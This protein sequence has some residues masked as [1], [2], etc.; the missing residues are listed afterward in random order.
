MIYVIL[1]N[2]GNNEKMKNLQKICKYARKLNHR[3]GEAILCLRKY[4]KKRVL[5]FFN[6]PK[7]LSDAPY[8]IASYEYST[9]HA[10]PDT[11]ID[12]EKMYECKNR[13]Q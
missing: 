7:K 4:N 9:G 8:C 3:R 1:K 5:L 2:Y 10:M 13:K 12:I 11:D 6:N